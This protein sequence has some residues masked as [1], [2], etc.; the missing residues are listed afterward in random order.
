MKD[1]KAFRTLLTSVL[2]SAP[3]PLVLGAGLIV[4]RSSTQLADFA[5]RSAELIALIVALV[6]F[7]ITE[8]KQ[9][10]SE[11]EKERI[12]RRGNTL[13]GVIMCISGLIMLM[14]LVLFGQSEKGNVI[15]ACVIA[16]MGVVVNSTFFFRYTNHYKRT[17]NSILGVQGRLYG[18][19]SLVDICVTTSLLMIIIF[20]G[21]MISEIFDRIGTMV[22]SLYMLY[23][24]GR[25]IMEAN[26]RPYKEKVE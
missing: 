26:R 7:C 13:V 3:G 10:S 18:A 5:R 2:L 14:V 6:V 8:K 21:A 19:K 22:V 23:C 24:G 16:F 17:G 25:T 15:P 9:E 1:K 4:G 12:K 11:D 20:P